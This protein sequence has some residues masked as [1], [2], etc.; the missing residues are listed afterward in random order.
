M[1]AKVVGFRESEEGKNN[2]AYCTALCD[3]VK[4]VMVLTT[5]TKRK[6]DVGEEIDVVYSPKIGVYFEKQ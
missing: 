2:L 4:G 3:N 5:L 6:C 1:K